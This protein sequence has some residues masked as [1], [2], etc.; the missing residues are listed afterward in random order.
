MWPDTAACVPRI[1]EEYR[2]DWRDWASGVLG[3]PA[4]RNDFYVVNA[5]VPAVFPS[6]PRPLNHR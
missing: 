4:E 1:A 6:G 2:L 5:A 3:P